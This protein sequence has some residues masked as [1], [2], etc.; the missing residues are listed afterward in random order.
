MNILFCFIKNRKKIWDRESDWPI[1]WGGG[2]GIWGFGA[3][4]CVF[5]KILKRDHKLKF[6]LLKVDFLF[7]IHDKLW[8]KLVDS[9]KRLNYMGVFIAKRFNAINNYK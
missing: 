5:K 2:G 1:V 7:R 6:A 9:V 4:F 3:L 8:F